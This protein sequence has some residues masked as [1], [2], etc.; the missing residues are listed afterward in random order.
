MEAEAKSCALLI[1][2]MQKDFVLPDGANPVAGAAAIIPYVQKTLEY[3]RGKQWPVFHVI[4]EHRPDGSD[5]EITRLKNFQD[6]GPY[7]VPGTRGWELVDE[8]KPLPGEYRIAKRRFSAFMSTELDFILKRLGIAHIV[9]C[10]NQYPT[11]IRC[12]VFDAV[13][14]GYH[15]TLLTDATSAHSVEIAQANIRDIQNIG[16]LCRTVEEFLST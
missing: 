9:V 6:Q 1:I 3:F 8:L 16:V 13:A 5:V 2:D 7:A 10:G 14:Y 4:R 11:C 12:T 15:V